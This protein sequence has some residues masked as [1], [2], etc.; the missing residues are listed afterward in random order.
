MYTQLYIY[1]YTIVYRYIY[2]YKFIFFI[3][4]KYIQ[5][6]ICIYTVPGSQLILTEFFSLHLPVLMKRTAMTKAFIIQEEFVWESCRNPLG[7][8]ELQSPLCVMGKTL[9]N[10]QGSVYQCWSFLFLVIKGRGGM[11]QDRRS[12]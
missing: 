5:L 11:L 9:S 10:W 7:S 4:C 1:V 8:P 2:I 6:Y 12:P 3:V